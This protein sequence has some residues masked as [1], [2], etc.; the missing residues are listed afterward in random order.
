[1]SYS[2]EF[3]NCTLPQAPISQGVFSASDIE[4][5]TLNYQNTGDIELI[6]ET[7]PVNDTRTERTLGSV[8]MTTLKTSVIAAEVTPLNGVIRYGLV[9][10]TTLAA[11]GNS[12]AAA[13]ALGASTLLLEGGAALAS[14][15]ALTSEKGNKSLSLVNKGLDHKWFKR[16][17]P[18][19]VKLN[20]SVEAVVGL[21]GGTSILLTLKQRE[22]QERSTK[23][24]RKYGLLT[25]AYL[26]GVCTLQGYAIS[27]GVTNI[28]DPK[29]VTPAAVALGGMFAG[30][31]WLKKRI[32]KSNEQKLTEIET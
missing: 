2:E 22:D 18:H 31:T 14:A 16:V 21:Y 26:T 1:M 13:G 19:E 11:T 29:I 25:T 6:P 28:T 30:F 7:N 20:P 24:L 9:F 3:D 15:D 5:S 27:E 17:I 8:A 23:Q 12:F 32:I 10:G 4:P